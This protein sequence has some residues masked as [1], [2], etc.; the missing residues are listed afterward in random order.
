MHHIHAAQTLNGEEI[1]SR[2][3]IFDV[4]AQESCGNFPDRRLTHYLQE[5]VFL[6]TRFIWNPYF[7]VDRLRALIVLI[8]HLEEVEN[9]FPKTPDSTISI[10]WIGKR[11]LHDYIQKQIFL[12]DTHPKNQH[13]YETAQEDTLVDFV[14]DLES[15]N[16]IGI[17]TRWVSGIESSLKNHAETAFNADILAKFRSSVLRSFLA[18]YFPE[19]PYNPYSEKWI[20]M[21]ERFAY[22][23]DSNNPYAIGILEKNDPLEF[24]T[25]DSNARDFNISKFP[26]DFINSLSHFTAQVVYV[27]TRKQAIHPD[28][29]AFVKKPFFT[30]SPDISRISKEQNA[31][32]V[33]MLYP[34]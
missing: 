30:A 29:L 27:L 25:S 19:S 16:A 15:L 31:R 20:Q 32:L 18:F 11:Q 24:A 28:Q 14:R 5:F 3:R 22:K 13:F 9:S 21:V 10:L 33:E 6:K 34:N 8:F 26:L 1:A 7:P 4:L 2:T 12:H 17:R 23:K